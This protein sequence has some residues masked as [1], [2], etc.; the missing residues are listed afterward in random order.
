M[1]TGTATDLFCGAGGMP[2]AALWAGVQVRLAVDRWSVALQT[3][4]ANHPQTE[5]V[6]V[7]LAEADPRQFWRTDA[8]LASPP[9]TAF[10]VAA[11]R[12]RRSGQQPR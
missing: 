11:G 8:L 1:S 10:S 5:Q 4:A 2:L 7:D 3:H 6:H 12:R 9:C